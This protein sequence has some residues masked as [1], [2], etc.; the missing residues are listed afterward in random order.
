MSFCG[1]VQLLTQ[2]AGLHM[3]AKAASITS[4][5]WTGSRHPEISISGIPA[6]TGIND[7]MA[8]AQS[9]SVDTPVL[10]QGRSPA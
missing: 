8:G 7:E 3:L 4:G 6:G 2:S 10:M 9:R 5:L 1:V